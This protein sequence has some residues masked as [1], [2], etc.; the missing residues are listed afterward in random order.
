MSSFDGGKAPGIGG[1]WE[2]SYVGRRLTHFPSDGRK[3]EFWMLVMDE[4]VATSGSVGG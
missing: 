2:R 4:R 3:R 1:R